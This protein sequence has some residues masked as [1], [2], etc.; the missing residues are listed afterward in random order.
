MHSRSQGLRCVST[1][2]LHKMRPTQRINTIDT[3]TAE[4][5]PLAEMY[6]ISP[7]IYSESYSCSIAEQRL[8]NSLPRTEYTPKPLNP[9]VCEYVHIHVY[10]VTYSL[11]HIR[12]I[13]VCVRVQAPEALH[14][15]HAMY[16][17]MCVCNQSMP[18]QSPQ[19]ISK[20]IYTYVYIWNPADQ[21]QSVR[22][23]VALLQAIE[24]RPYQK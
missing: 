20:L 1:P 13:Y 19:E 16:R 15:Q 24:I 2:G 23:A 9:H 5:L 18:I 10:T 17:P 6:I 22:G 3:G 8:Y 12:N 21:G 14:V 4:K 11:I 7:W